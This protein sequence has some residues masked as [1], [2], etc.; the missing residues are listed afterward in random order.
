MTKIL[1]INGRILN[2]LGSREPD[3]YGE[4]NLNNIESLL[5]DEDKS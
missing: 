1:L 4:E 5:V 2:L 3:V